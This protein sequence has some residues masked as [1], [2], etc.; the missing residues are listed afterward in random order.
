M[1]H[2][3]RPIKLNY[4][5]LMTWDPTRGSNWLSLIGRQTG[6]GFNLFYILES[7]HY[8]ADIQV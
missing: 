7:K 6:C 1:I 3:Y 8:N 2:T 5:I 4:H